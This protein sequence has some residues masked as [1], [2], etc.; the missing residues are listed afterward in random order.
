[1]SRPDIMILRSIQ[2]GRRRRRPNVHAEN[3]LGHFRGYIDVILHEFSTK[4]HDSFT[5]CPVPIGRRALRSPALL[6][7][8]AP[9]APPHSP[10]LLAARAPLPA[11]PRQCP[12]TAPRSCT[13]AMNPRQKKASVS[14]SL[15][16]LRRAGYV[17]YPAPVQNGGRATLGIGGRLHHHGT[18]E[19]TN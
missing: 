8:R 2:D 12:P 16:L 17:T 1:M 14:L 18:K 9:P 19:N 6:A 7:A 15:L 13:S 4:I 11:P 5:L 3:H 10:A